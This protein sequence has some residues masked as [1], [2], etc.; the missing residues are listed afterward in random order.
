VTSSPT[1][2]PTIAPTESPTVT[3]TEPLIIETPTETAS[4]ASAS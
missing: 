3:P 1:V 2:T 4:N